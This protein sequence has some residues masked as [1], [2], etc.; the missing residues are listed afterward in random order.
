MPETIN[1]T[2]EE[3]GEQHDGETPL[4][5]ALRET[6]E[7]LEAAKDRPLEDIES[8]IGEHSAK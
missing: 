2:P 3:I 6:Q 5:K 1:P 7:A 4:E 8:E